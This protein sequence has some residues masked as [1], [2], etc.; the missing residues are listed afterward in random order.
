MSGMHRVDKG[1]DAARTCRVDLPTDLQA[2]DLVATKNSS[3]RQLRRVCRNGSI[4][5]FS[6]VA[7]P[8]TR[9]AP[10]QLRGALPLT[11]PTYHTW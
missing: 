7:R 10:L 3:S 8:H 6:S 11:F 9:M 5:L 2:R 4:L 1:T